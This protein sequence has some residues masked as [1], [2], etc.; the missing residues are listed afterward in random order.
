M[1]EVCHLDNVISVFAHVRGWSFRAATRTVPTGQENGV[2]GGDS[3]REGRV[4]WAVIHPT[5]SASPEKGRGVH[6][7]CA[8]PVDTAILPGERTAPPRTL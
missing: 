8:D 1:R 6:R 7:A 2:G 4:R 3:R 5:R